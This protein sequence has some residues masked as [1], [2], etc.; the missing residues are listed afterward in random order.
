M[1]TNYTYADESLWMR[2]GRLS[3][4]ISLM[5]CLRIDGARAC[6]RNSC[7]QCMQVSGVPHDETYIGVFCVVNK[8]L[9]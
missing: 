3:G 6:L 5:A 8:E 4:G 2:D 9:F 1:L 7:I